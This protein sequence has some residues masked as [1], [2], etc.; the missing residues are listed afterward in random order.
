VP[1]ATE[2]WV[3]ATPAAAPLPFYGAMFAVLRLVTS[4]P[5]L[6]LWLPRHVLR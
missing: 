1:D 5:D 6:S 2:G 3:G 4:I